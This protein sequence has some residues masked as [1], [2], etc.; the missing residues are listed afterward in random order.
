MRYEFTTDVWRWDGGAAASWWFA[1]VPA[2]MSAGLKAMRGKAR[3]W[4]SV[5][6]RAETGGVS[7]RTS[8]FPS[9]EGV[10]LLPVKAEVRRQAGVTPGEPRRFVVEL[11]V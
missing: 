7:W 8:L 11:E 9:R 3:G 1:T 6:V 4:G 2:D 5:R 10:F